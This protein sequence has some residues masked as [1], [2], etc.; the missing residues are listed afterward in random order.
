[1]GC[2]FFVTVKVKGYEVIVQG[3]PHVL[4]TLQ[5]FGQY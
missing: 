2:Y 4:V 5:N 3:H 1:M